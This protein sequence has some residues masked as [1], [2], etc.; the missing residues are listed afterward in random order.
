VRRGRARGLGVTLISQR[1]ALIH[2]DVLTQIEVL[3]AHRLTGPHDRDAIERW[4]EHHAD[5]LQAREVLSSLAALRDGDAWVWSPGWL[6]LFQR[7]RIRPRT[8]F[9]SSATPRVGERRPM[10]VVVAKADLD[11]LRDRMAATVQ[12]AKADDPRELR[13]RIEQ[14]EAELRAASAAPVRV[15]VPVLGGHQVEQLVEAAASLAS[16]AAGLHAAIQRVSSPPSDASP[17]PA[18]AAPPAAA[19]APP[20]K[21][22]PVRPV[23]PSPSGQLEDLPPLRAGERRMLDTLV[24]HHPMK[25]TRS[26]LGT[27]AGFAARGGTF[28]T[29]FGTLKRR[30]LVVEDRDGL[31]LTSEGLRE[32]GGTPARPQTT[33]EILETWR[34]ALRAGERRML[35]VL[36]EARPNRLTRAELGIRSGFESSGGTFGTY[37]G[38]L[39]RN[40]LVD[41]DGDQVR[42]S[43]TLFLAG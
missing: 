27:I 42:V 37:L 25:M 2:K 30:G 16:I 17:S 10:P 11:M 8:T 40:G 20:P 32:G 13:R 9:D 1:P 26:Q 35:D 21:A 18:P 39:R 23:R 43:E 22:P 3:V 38:S 19:F 33:H 29:Y 7:V 31:Q 41:V 34:R 5:E 4:V 36:L 6:G 28:G 24:R 12:R 14:L 15:E